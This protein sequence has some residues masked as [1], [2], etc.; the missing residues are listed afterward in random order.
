M[1]DWLIP[2]LTF[3]SGIAGGF[4]GARGTQIRLETQMIDV[5]DRLTGMNK[6]VSRHND[7][8]LVH[9]MELETALAKLDIPRVRRQRLPE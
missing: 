7:D 9:D 2:V 5:R 8:L 4:M 6:Q 1:P 3:M